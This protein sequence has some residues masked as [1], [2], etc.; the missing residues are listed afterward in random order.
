MPHAPNSA[1]TWAPGEG[2][3]REM[4][5]VA[6]RPRSPPSRPLLSI[7]ASCQRLGRGPGTTAVTR[8][9]HCRIAPLQ[10]RDEGEGAKNAEDTDGARRTRE[11]APVTPPP[12]LPCLGHLHRVTVQT[13]VSWAGRAGGSRQ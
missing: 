12:P 3:L 1:P 2:K 7:T 8:H 9:P 4:T 11:Q 5:H 10:V 6:P 13:R